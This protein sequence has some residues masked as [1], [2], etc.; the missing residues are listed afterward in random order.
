[1]GTT[2]ASTRTARGQALVEFALV[3]P[4]VALVVFGIIVLGLYV[5]YSQEITNA[6]REAARYAAIH[7]STAQ[8]PT[9]SWQDPQTPPNSYW[10]CD[11]PNNPNG[12]DPYPWPNMTNDARSMIW[13]VA[14]SSVI[15]NAC[16]SGYVPPGSAPGTLA[17]SPAVD[18]ATR[19]P[20]DYVQ[21]TI[22]G[23]DPINSPGALGCQPSL[24]TIADD[25]A[26]D[27]PSNRVTA[28]V[29]MV[30]QP[31]MAGFLLIPSQVTIRGVVTEDI[32]RQQ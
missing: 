12:T 22:G 17:D 21:C 24:T 10:R 19:M 27:Q 18:P 31:P 25:P 2:S 9:V 5:F 14:S 26:S 8:C 32:Q 16:W 29:C 7:S 20:N 1:M 13:G 4:L 30:W 11:S 28:Y 23:T 3:F 6:A 15:V